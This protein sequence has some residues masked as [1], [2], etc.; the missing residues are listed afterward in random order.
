[1][2]HRLLARLRAL[3]AFLADP[4]GALRRAD[5]ELAADER[6]LTRM[7]E[8][9]ARRSAPKRIV[10][11][12]AD[13]P[14]HDCRSCLT[15]MPAWVRQDARAPDY[16]RHLWPA[17]GSIDQTVAWMISAWPDAWYFDPEVRDVAVALIAVRARAAKG[18]VTS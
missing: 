2:R 8:A 7:R 6:L 12:S 14:I 1:M 4:D 15:E 10:V 11:T 17:A 13:C 16:A 3:A 18:L 5:E 9:D